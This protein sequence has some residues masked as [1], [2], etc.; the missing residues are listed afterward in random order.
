MIEEK[1]RLGWEFLF[2]G[3]NIDAK[4]TAEELGIDVSQYK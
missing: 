2:I 1:R 3:A 4:E